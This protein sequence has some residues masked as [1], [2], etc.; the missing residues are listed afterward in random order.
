MLDSLASHLLRPRD[1]SAGSDEI[2]DL[3]RAFPFIPL[4]M[5][6]GLAKLTQSVVHQRPSTDDP[7]LSGRPF[8]PLM[9]LFHLLMRFGELLVTLNELGD[10]PCT[11][12]QAAAILG[13]DVKHHLE[14]SSTT[15]YAPFCR[16]FEI[17]F[18]GALLAYLTWFAETCYPQLSSSQQ[19]KGPALVQFAEAFVLKCLYSPSRS[20]PVR[21]A[22]GNLLLSA[23]VFP[24]MQDIIRWQRAERVESLLR[25]SAASFAGL[26][27]LGANY[28]YVLS[29]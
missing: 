4:V 17:W 18:R 24:W 13:W 11:L 16:L 14:P 28:K 15:G 23:A 20:C 19:L 9:G 2:A 8:K 26:N 27:N 21:Q 3:Q 10:L 1:E 25:I 5:D 22:V 6:Q 7:A 12:R 29:C